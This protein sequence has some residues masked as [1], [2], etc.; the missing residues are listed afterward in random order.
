MFK[1]VVLTLALFAASP[2]L[3]QSSLG[4]QGA[5]LRFGALQDE[6]GN[7]QSDFRLGLDVAITSAHGFQGDV[8]LSDTDYGL[9]GQL[10]AHLYMDP[11]ANQKYGVFATLADVDGRT[12]SWAALGVE[13]MLAL[14]SSTTIQIQ[15]GMGIS[16]V[17]GLDFIF[18]GIS[19]VHAI[20][21]TAEIEGSLDLVEFDEAGFQAIA[22][23]IG[24]SAR[25][26]PSGAPWGIYGN[27][28]Q[29][30]L[31]GASGAPGETRLGL[32][33]SWSLGA[34]GGVSP[35]TRQFRST[36][37]VASLVRRDLW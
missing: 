15:T 26:S 12:M 19:S 21:S 18:A 36:D 17:N 31:T 7:A 23:D 20:S 14:N 1:S 35:T 4:I 11:V 2:V 22:Y 9:I 34:S 8:I 13:G 3:A 37:P 27:L 25:Y 30:G 28:T 5:E 29:S 10:G 32:G 6:D 24:L 33:I 16:D